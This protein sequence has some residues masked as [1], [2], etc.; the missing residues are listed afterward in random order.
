MTIGYNHNTKHYAHLETNSYHNKRTSTHAFDI[1]ASCF[2][3]TYSTRQPKH[4]D[5]RTGE[6]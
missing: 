1:D 2:P 6:L 4:V 5:R 3:A